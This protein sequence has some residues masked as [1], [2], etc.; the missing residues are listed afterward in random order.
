MIIS[1]SV[2]NF[3]SFSEEQTF[4]LVASPRISGAHPNHAVAIPNSK[5]SVLSASVLYGAN[6]AGKSNLFKALRFLKNSVLSTRKK[7]SGTGR[8]PF[9][10][11]DSPNPRSSFDLQFI[12]RDKVYRFGITID[13]AKVAEEWLVKVSNGRERVIYERIT[14]DDGTV[15]IESPGLKD[16]RLHALATVGGLP[17]Q[18][19][20]ATVNATL[21]EASFGS[22]LA[23]VLG[24]FKNSLRLI[25]PTE[26]YQALGHH[27]SE[28]V[29]FLEFAGE[30]LRASSTG[31]DSLEVEKKEISWDELSRLLPKE[32]V[33]KLIDDLNEDERGMA[34]IR[35][36]EGNEVVLERSSESHFYKITVN[37]IHKHSHDQRISLH[38]AQ[39]SDGTRRLLNLLP[40]LRHVR[41]SDAV[42]FIDEIDRSMHPILVWKFLE[43]FL[44]SCEG[45][46]RQ[47]IVTTH[48]SNLLDLELLRRDEIWFAEKDG[49]GAT[50]LHSLAD[51]K[52]RKDLEIRKHY[53]QG[54]FGGIPYLANLDRLVETEECA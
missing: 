54:R 36:G 32:K 26:S 9:L 16:K 35:L 29:D 48:E 50:H 31:I 34:L 20:L 4:S 45:A 40:A 7:G 39:E 19:F 47:I 15:T 22:D 44:K 11:S 28:D 17:N 13:D 38:L 10:F 27:F 42:Y 23:A 1:F 43:F 53:L 41:T 37:A 46:H 2:E 52:V 21:E 33:T 51:F 6:G 8:E 25:A 24:W 14:A 3:R 30:Y 49:S 5:E 18:T 12:A